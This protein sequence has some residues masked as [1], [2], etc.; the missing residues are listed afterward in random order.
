MKR[1]R[2]II[3]WIVLLALLSLFVY[4]QF[5]QQEPVF[6]EIQKEAVV[7]ETLYSEVSAT[8]TINPIEMV[9]VGTQVS[10][11][12][13][14]VLVDFNDEVKAGQMLARM[15][16]R[17]LNSTL[18]ESKAN[19]KKATV[20]LQQTERA[21]DRNKALFE[22][23]VIAK[24]IFEKAQDDY[25]SAKA[26]YNIAKLQLDKN[27]VNLGYADII[28]PIDGVVISKEVDVGQTI[29]ASFSTPVLFS[30]A[31]DLKKMKIE[32][33]VDE[34][35]I[36]Q[37]QEY[38][39]VL[40][41]VDSYP[42]DSFNGVVAQVQLK[43]TVVQ[44]VVTYN[45]IILIEN[46]DLKLMPGMTATL[47]IR[48]EERPNSI[49]VPNSALSF[50]PFEEDDKLLKRKKY[51]IEPL[52]KKGTKSIWMLRDKTFNEVEVDV[53]YSNGIRTAIISDLTP[54]D[55]VITNIKITVGEDKGG[56]FLVPN[57][58]EEKDNRPN[59]GMHN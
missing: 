29:A 15:D 57:N 48:T 56:S 43:P 17:I 14:E 18:Q 26:T 7:E 24:V 11:K 3:I 46:P 35:D 27:S 6:I 58:D 9:D 52:H 22:D 12:I 13:S 25:N 41:T 2:N 49:S 37:V 4:K 31:K 50:D 42:D 10:G 34:A 45:V 39:E 59:G 53:A 51:T 44:N 36:G 38:Q 28:S 8:G 33:S 55:S 5:I 54:G 23:G 47:I 40:F 32:A 21:L 20:I 30:I 16:M 19:L 1:T